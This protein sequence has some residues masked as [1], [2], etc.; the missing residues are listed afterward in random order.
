MQLSLARLVLAAVAF[1]AVTHTASAA[2]EDLSRAACEGDA[3]CVFTA[4][5]K[6][7]K[8][9]TF[10]TTIPSTCALVANPKDGGTVPVGVKLGDVCLQVTGEDCVYQSP[11]RR[12]KRVI[13]P[14]ACLV[15]PDV[16]LLCSGAA[17]YASLMP[18]SIQ[19]TC[20]DLIV[21]EDCLY[22][23]TRKKG[24]RTIRAT[25]ETMPTPPNT[26]ADANAWATTHNLGLE[27]ACDLAVQE[28]EFFA[29]VR[30]KRNGRMRV[31][32][33]ARCDIPATS[34]PTPPVT[35]S[36]TSAPTSP[37]PT[38]AP[39]SPPTSAPTAAPCNPTTRCSGRYVC[40]KLNNAGTNNL[41][42]DNVGGCGNQGLLYQNF[43]CP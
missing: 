4:G 39:T 28:C 6:R 13:R 30:R 42:S 2:C 26:C 41:C 17:E 43:F 8:F 25:C 22:R 40:V 14:A 33:S 36:P 7:N 24:R 23:P 27:D 38:F 37:P 31:I 32:Q 10:C 20:S 35:A 29:A 18:S 3:T 21:A 11:I 15:E 5:T 12:G 34:A 9:R 16:P 19:E 1:S